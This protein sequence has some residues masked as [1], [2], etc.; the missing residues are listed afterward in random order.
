MFT[1]G[2]LVGVA[3]LAALSSILFLFFR[4]KI[5]VINDVRSGCGE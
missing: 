3:K 1:M 4:I 5:E 2:I